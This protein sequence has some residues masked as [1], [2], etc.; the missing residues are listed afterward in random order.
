MN[1]SIHTENAKYTCVSFYCYYGKVNR[2]IDA[3]IMLSAHTHTH[4]NNFILKNYCDF[5]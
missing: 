5:I 1:M 3:H 4:N 2:K